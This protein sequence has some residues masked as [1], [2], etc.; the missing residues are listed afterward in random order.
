[1]KTATESYTRRMYSEF[2]AE[3]KD[4]FYLVTLC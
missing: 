2:Q 1:L 4:Q 3:F